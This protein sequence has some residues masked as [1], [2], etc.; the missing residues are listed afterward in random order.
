M[1]QTPWRDGG[2]SPGP[3]PEVGIGAP[4]TS[5]LE[6]DGEPDVHVT[7]IG[8]G[9]IGGVV[10]AYLARHGDDVLFVDVVDEHVEA[11]N[12]DG[13]TIEGVDQFSVAAPAR[14]P[15][16]LSGPL[17]IVI[18]AVKS[19]HTMDALEQ[20]V[21][22]FSEA[23]LLISLQNGLNPDKIAARIGAQRVVGGFVNFAADY[24]GPG[25]ISYGGEGDIY[26]GRLDGPPD[27][28]LHAIA[29]KFERIMNT[30][31]TDNI[32]GYLWSKQCYGAALTAT[33]LVDAPVHEILAS[34][35]NRDV[36]TATVQES[37]AVA[38]AAGVTLKA[39]EPFE[40][41]LFRAPIDTD[42]L[43]DLYDRIAER[44]RTRVKTHTGI[45]R[46]LKV[47]KR[48]TE[49]PWLT[50]D[51][52]RRGE[53]MGL[54]LPVCKR[55]VEMIVEIEYGRREQSQANLDELHALLVG[56]GV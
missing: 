7:V 46:D 43:N 13:L 8:S 38:D 24:A 51:V 17:D 3:S 30:V 18:L 16:Q 42:R 52:V 15:N 29:A 22:L 40:P 44:F 35:A 53:E 14:T 4:L 54:L 21:P 5:K 36:L 2:P 25:R 49:V 6:T 31:L 50:G 37:I 28:R 12:R 27:E 11:M 34:Q 9:A 23:S 20:V 55:M 39:F 26:L 32:M 47:R 10:G 41:D 33:A 19:Q 45:W 48:K 1:W 56:S